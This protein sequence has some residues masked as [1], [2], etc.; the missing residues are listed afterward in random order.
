MVRVGNHLGSDRA[1]AAQGVE[2]GRELVVPAGEQERGH[3]AWRALQT[4]GQR[5]DRVGY[6]ATEKLASLLPRGVVGAN[7]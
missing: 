6:R 7:S 1:R 5:G 2:C 3:L 4:W